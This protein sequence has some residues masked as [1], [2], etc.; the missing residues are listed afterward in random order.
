MTHPLAGRARRGLIAVSALVAASLALSACVPIADPVSTSSPTP[1]VTGVAEELLPFYGQDIAW[2]DCDDEFDCATVTAPLDWDDPSAGAIEL[3]VIRH[4]PESGEPIGSLLTNPGGPGASGVSLVRDSLSTA[5]GERLAAAYD[6][7]G[8]DPRGVGES[9]GVRCYDAADMDS[10]LF[11]VPENTRGT[12]AWEDELAARHQGFADACDANSDGILPFITTVNAAR[13]MDLLRA[14]LGDTALNYLGYSYGTFLGATYAELYPDRVGRLVLDGAIDPAVSGPDVGATQAIGFESALRAYMADCLA[15]DDCPF[16]GTVDEG[17]A[18]LGSLLASVDRSPL[19][20]SD[21]RELGADSLMTT[22]VTALY[23]EDSW[24]YLT[25]ALTEVLQGD[26]STAFVIADFYYN[27]EDGTYLD[28]QTEA[29]RAYNCMD[30]PAEESDAATALIAEKAPTIAP[31]WDGPDSCAD[32]PYPP[33]GTRG[34]IAAE[35][36]AP[37]VVVGTTNDPATPYEWA[38]S[39][40]DQL[41]SG[42]L[43]TRVGEGHTG[44]NKGNDCVD[45]AVEDYLI[46]GTV[47]EDGLRCE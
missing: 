37:I 6:V 32:W 11:D 12:S 13:D 14:V 22:I 16:R 8:F 7:I 30:Y 10:Y 15:G 36:A 21:G 24:P 5:V 4:R 2:A 28:N 31:Y 17:M 25:Q 29:F 9:T 19:P 42:V 43:I 27:R 46:D 33:T 40:A 3:S 47:P 35:G 23:S 26:P 20:S 34:P 44:Y 45:A 1:D 18:D 41:S 38:V 39:L